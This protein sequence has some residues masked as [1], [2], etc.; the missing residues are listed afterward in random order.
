MLT[1]LLLAAAMAA[2]PAPA[3]TPA[4]PDADP[5]LWVVKDEDTTIYLFGTFHALDG[6]TD[7]FNEEVKT[8][9]DQSGEL[10]LEALIPEDPA[11][12]QPVVMKYALDTS[13]KPLTAKLSPDAQKAMAVEL[14]KMGAPANA[15]DGFKPYF[16]SMT[17][18]MVQ[19]QKLGVAADK[20]TEAILRKAAKEAGKPVG[21]LENVEFQMAM[22]DRISEASQV[23]MLEQTLKSLEEIPADTARMLA[24]WNGGDA[25]GFKKLMDES[26]AEGPEAYKVIFSDRNATWAEWVDNR[27]DKPGTVFVAVGTGHLAGKDSVQQLLD[28]RG[29]TST[30]VN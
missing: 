18:V 27:L 23:Q 3:A 22:F 8:A 15:F 19:M 30:R 6:K 17:L 7:W 20:G 10:V 16:A 12:M 24:A 5:A 26:S 13:G 29:I 2:A 25:A 28:K 1:K 21:E 4:L 14:G 9:F 11:A